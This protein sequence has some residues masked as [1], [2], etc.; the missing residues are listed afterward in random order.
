M[1]FFYK[2]INMVNHSKLQLMYLMI[3]FGLSIAQLNFY[4]VSPTESKKLE[5]ATKQTSNKNEETG[6]QEETAT[7]KNCTKIFLV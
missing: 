7:T 6:N 2:E 3:L 1:K 5:N 4:D